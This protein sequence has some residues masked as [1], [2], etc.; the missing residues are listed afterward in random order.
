MVEVVIPLSV[1]SV[2]ALRGSSNH[3]G[4]VAGAFSDD[5]DLSL[6][7]GDLTVHGL[8]ELPQDVVGAEIIHP[9]DRI[10]T[11]PVDMVLGHPIER[12]AD[13]EVSDLIAVGS[14]VVHRSAP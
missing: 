13:D 10:Q 5:E 2:S 8:G 7:S 6:E 11:K 1:E 4:I 9:V 12:V 14:V 3:P